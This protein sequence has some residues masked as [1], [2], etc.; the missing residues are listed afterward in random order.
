MLHK[1]HVDPI[2]LIATGDHRDGDW[3]RIHC[4]GYFIAE[5]RTITELASLVDLTEL[6]EG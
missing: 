5:L 3:L 6:Q 2:P 1:D 4:D